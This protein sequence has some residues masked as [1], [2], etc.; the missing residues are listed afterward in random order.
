MRRLYWFDTPAGVYRAEAC[1]ITC[2][3]ARFELMARK[4]LQRRGVSPADHVR[5]AGGAKALSSP[6]TP[7]ERE[8]LLDQVRASIR[9]HATGRVVLMAHSDCGACGGLEAFDGDAAR[10][11][12]WHRAELA[13][14]AEAIRGA[15]PGL[16]IEQYFLDFTGVWEIPEVEYVSANRG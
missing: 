8:F 7:A 14:A 3:D 13:K 1:V 15:L 5:V 16:A 12:A 10:E 9:L 6:R 2:F 4:F 11:A